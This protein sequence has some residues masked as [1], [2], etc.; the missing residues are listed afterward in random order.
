[1]DTQIKEIH[2]QLD[3]HNHLK[4]HYTGLDFRTRYA[5]YNVWKLYMLNFI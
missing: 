2:K 4:A 3:V 1:M 5:F